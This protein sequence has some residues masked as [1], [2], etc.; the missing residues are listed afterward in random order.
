MNNLNIRPGMII[1]ALDG[2]GIGKKCGRAVLADDVD[3]LHEVSRRIDAAQDLILNWASNRD[4]IKI[5][6]G[7][8]EAV[9][10]LDNKY[11]K[12]IEPLRQ[13]IEKKF[14]YTI[15]VGVGKSL[16]EAG[17][18]LL[19]AKLRGKNRV[20]Y[21]NKYIKEDIKKAKRRVREKRASQEE[22][23]LAEAYLEKSELMVKTCELHKAGPISQPIGKPIAGKNMV[24]GHPSKGLMG[25]SDIGAS[26]RGEDGKVNMGRAKREA[27]T[28]LEAERAIP[29]P[30][31]GKAEIAKL[32][33]LHKSKL[34]DI[35]K[36]DEGAHI[37][38]GNEDNRVDDCAM[39]QDLDAQENADGT[40]GMHDNCP[41]CQQYDEADQN[42]GHIDDCPYC[43]TENITESQ[44]NPQSMKI[45]ANVLG[46]QSMIRSNPV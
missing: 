28:S 2:D 21:F 16:S 12:D 3:A 10:A 6:G 20:V 8:D 41:A 19:V 36:S 42:T 30:N 23:K 9:I 38:D 26:V 17:T 43:Q 34:C 31:L 24:A 5:S 7:G 46:V 35:H 22:Y 15:S 11:R 13:E 29:K 1:V 18:A 45:V 37:H 14:D 44:A 25:T 33:G 39:C 40:A 4:G 27:K 32:C